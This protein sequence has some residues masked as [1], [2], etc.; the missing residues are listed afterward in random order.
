MDSKRLWRIAFG[1]G[2]VG[3]IIALM[4]ILRGALTPVFVALILA[5]L[6]DPVIDKLEERRIPRSVA[7]FILAAVATVVLVVAGGFLVFQAQREISKVIDNMPGYLERAQSELAPL[8]REH[9]GVEIP[10]TFTGVMDEAKAQLRDIDPA[11]LR[12]VTEAI[13]NATSSTLNFLSSLIGLIIIPVFLYY[14]LRDWDTLKYQALDYVPPR[15]R[16]YVKDKGIKVDEVL[17]AF[18][19]GQLTVALILGV[20]YSAGLLTVGIDLAVVI[21]MLSGIAFIVPYL[22]TVLGVIAATIMALLEGGISWQILGAWGVFAVVQ[23]IEGT[24]IT[25]KI[26]GDKVGLSPVIVIISLLIGA[27]L[28]GLLGMLVAVPSAAVLKVFVREWIDR[29]QSSEFFN[30]GTPEHKPEADKGPPSPPVS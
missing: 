16:E 6:L 1:F 17:G 20:L 8:A 11:S 26:M 21:G 18:L 24:I 13:G 25:P 2:L 15:W 19:R 30:D 3:G 9:L 14:F 7:I 22:G 10:E 29:Y 5:Y 28:L 4:Y 27:E 12:P 23:S